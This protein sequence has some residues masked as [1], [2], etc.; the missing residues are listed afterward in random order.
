MLPNGTPGPCLDRDPSRRPLFPFLGNPSGAMLE[1]SGS[2]GAP[3]IGK[4]HSRTRSD[5][6]FF[7]S[8][9]NVKKTPIF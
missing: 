7:A 2:R 8:E 3:K 6:L 1:P 9:K 4:I 5:T